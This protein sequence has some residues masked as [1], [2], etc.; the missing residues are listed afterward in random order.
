MSA[1]LGPQVML[2]YDDRTGE[3]V[4]QVHGHILLLQ[5]LHV[6]LLLMTKQSSILFASCVINQ[7][8]SAAVILFSDHMLTAAKDFHQ[9]N[10]QGALTKTVFYHTHYASCDLH[11]PND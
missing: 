10:Q 7:G 8:H 6:S 1:P 5:H 3:V 4:E 9:V 2:L 11:N